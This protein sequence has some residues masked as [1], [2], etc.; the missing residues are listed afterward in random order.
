MAQA[1]TRTLAERYDYGTRLR[2]KAPREKHADLRGSSARD[3]AARS[4]WRKKSGTSTTA[5]CG[6]SSTP[7]SPRLPTISKKTTTSRTW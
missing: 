6:A 2:K 3:P 5:R 1:L 4:S 7:S